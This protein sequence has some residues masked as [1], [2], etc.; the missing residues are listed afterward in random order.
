MEKASPAPSG[1]WSGGNGVL[2]LLQ[3]EALAWMRPCCSEPCHLVA[4]AA[5][6]REGRGCLGRLDESRG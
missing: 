6:A 2:S 1:S 4:V 3:D 5:A